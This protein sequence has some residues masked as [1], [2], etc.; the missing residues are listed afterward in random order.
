MHKPLYAAAAAALTVILL[1][2]AGAQTATQNAH[3]AAAPV[4][5]SATAQTS[6]SVRVEFLSNQSTDEWRGTNLIGANVYGPDGK[7][8]GAINELV[9]GSQGEVHAVVIG[10]GGLLGIGEKNVAVP[11]RSLNIVRKPNASNIDKVTIAASKEQLQQAPK[12]V[13]LEANGAN[14]TTAGPRPPT[15]KP[16]TNA[17]GG[18]GPSPQGR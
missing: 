9:V 15:A 7:P 17:S 3:P 4:N 16:A 2:H 6:T 10:V 13:Y 14:N 18:T 11:F 8:I 1:G 5:I 12:F